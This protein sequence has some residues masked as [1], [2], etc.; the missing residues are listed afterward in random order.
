M[1]LINYI[2]GNRYGKEANRLER[3]SLEDAFLQEALDGYDTVISNHVQS[4]ERLEEKVHEQSK[5]KKQSKLIF[6]SSIAASIVLIIT[7]G[8]L[9][10]K[11]DKINDKQLIGKVETKIKKTE[12]KQEVTINKEAKKSVKE[13]N[14]VENIPPP[15]I[16]APEK[17][18]EKKSISAGVPV[19]SNKNEANAVLANKSVVSEN[20]Q[21]SAG[22]KDETDKAIFNSVAEVSERKAMA[23]KPQA[24][25][26]VS[27]A[28]KEQ[29][30][31]KQVKADKV[32]QKEFGKKEFSSFFMNKAK[33]NACGDVKAS[34]EVE[35]TLNVNQYP[36]SFKFP[37]FSC[38]EAKR[39]V[40]RIL[41]YSPRW[42]IAA[43]EKINMKFSW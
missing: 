35:F 17:N 19:S 16:T 2:K 6:Y 22:I 8:T 40:I 36:S 43:G 41:S 10:L 29:L 9:L 20:R 15:P 23:Y 4:I 21:A 26:S 13:E 33:K 18:I 34:V 14:T 7:L 25:A 1:K 12:K 38:E 5:N 24:V 11:H 30:K 3:E 32:E 37:K 31:E 39:E 28:T 27:N 42:T